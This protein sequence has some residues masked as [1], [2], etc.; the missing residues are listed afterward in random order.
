MTFLLDQIKI[1]SDHK[2]KKTQLKSPHACVRKVR[3]RFIVI[4][5]AVLDRIRES[6]LTLLR[7]LQS[8]FPPPLRPLPLLFLHLT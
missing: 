4:Y 7:F 1:R 5:R 2:K 3:I 6:C 8:P